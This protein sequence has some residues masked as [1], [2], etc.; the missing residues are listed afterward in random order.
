MADDLRARAEARLVA[1]LNERGL[2]DPRPALRQRLKRL[3]DADAAAFERARAHYEERTLPL[4]A[5][6]DPLEAWVEYARALGELGGGG[7]LVAVDASGRGREYEAPPQAGTLVLF[8]PTD[9]AAAAFAA[10]TPVSPSPAQ[11]AAFDL[12]VGGSVELR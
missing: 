1:A 11:S 5:E 10:L 12:L 6:G 7:R 8:I 3:R 2:A 4:L 9:D